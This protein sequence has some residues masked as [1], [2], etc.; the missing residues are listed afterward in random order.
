MWGPRL[1]EGL[2]EHAMA[3]SAAAFSRGEAQNTADCLSD[4]WK[5]ALQKRRDVVDMLEGAK[6]QPMADELGFWAYCLAN[7]FP[8]D[9]HNRLV[10]LMNESFDPT[11]GV[12]EA[13]RRQNTNVKVVKGKYNYKAL[14]MCKHPCVCRHVCRSL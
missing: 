2:T 8:A 14:N 6:L 4:S 1:C 10:T 9:M 11:K 5:Q 7:A 13:V 12:N 3:S